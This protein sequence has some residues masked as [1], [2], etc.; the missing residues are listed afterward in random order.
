M[1]L[2]KPAPR[3]CML[4]HASRTCG[5][6]SD[7]WYDMLDSSRVIGHKSKRLRSSSNHACCGVR[8]RAWAYKNGCVRWKSPNRLP[9]DA[10]A[11]PQ[12]DTPGLRSLSCWLTFNN[13]ASAHLLVLNITALHVPGPR[14]LHLGGLH[15][16]STQTVWQHHIHVHRTSS[17]RAVCDRQP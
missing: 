1:L 11:T 9:N 17:Q 12:P 8:Q 13:T 2:T 6:L 15:L 5:G 10:V 4:K 16:H 7:L 3:G 14:N